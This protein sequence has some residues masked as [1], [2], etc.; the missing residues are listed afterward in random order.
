MGFWSSLFGYDGPS[1]GSSESSSSG[2][3]A[4]L[5]FGKE[6]VGRS[7]GKL[8]TDSY[9]SVSDSGKTEKTGH[10]ECEPSKVDISR[11]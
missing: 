11:H 7:S 1:S 4:K 2:K 9:R 6:H 5:S 10:N 3:S 8:E